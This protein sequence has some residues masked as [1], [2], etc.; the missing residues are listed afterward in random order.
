MIVGIIYFSGLFIA[1]V[2]ILILSW[3]EYK[4]GNDISDLPTALCM[5][6]L[7]WLTVLMFAFAYKEIYKS[8]F[9][10]WFKK[11]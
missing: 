8:I 3:N 5:S 4:K 6:A 7:S 2:M 11:D 9:Q 10:K 1:L